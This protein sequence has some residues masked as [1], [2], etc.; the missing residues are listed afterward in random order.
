M[1]PHSAASTAS[2]AGTPLFVGRATLLRTLQVNLPQGR[3]Y[4][5]LAGPKTGRTALLQQLIWLEKQR[6]RTGGASMASWVP[7]YLDLR[8]ARPERPQFLFDA[9]WKAISKAVLDPWV[10][11]T[12]HFPRADLVDFKLEKDPAER[13][14]RA[15]EDL[16][17]QLANTQGW[18][19]WALLCDNA[20]VLAERGVPR[21]VGEQ[22][23]NLCS[24]QAPHCPT[25]MLWVGA[26]P[27][28]DM[29]TTGPLSALRRLPMGVL[30]DAE[31]QALYRAA[32]RPSMPYDAPWEVCVEATG[33][34]PM[35][36]MALMQAVIAQ[37]DAAF[38]QIREACAPEVEGV[39]AAYLACMGPTHDS[40]GHLHVVHALMQHLLSGGQD[41][42]VAEAEQLL[43]MR[44]VKEAIDMLESFA[45]IERTIRGNAPMLR[46]GN[47]W[48]NSW[49]AQ[50]ANAPMA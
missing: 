31:A 9:L 18:C 13:F 47:P 12:D 35:L 30:R 33:R 8:M 37:P 20:E 16:W 14:A 7:V 6:A 27:L 48:W 1:P 10:Q 44:P 49:Y 29:L 4:A 40:R 15:C 50:Q 21:H 5:L 45:V 22:L 25:S 23:M 3:S 17:A 41:L 19:R 36:L 32:G 24:L 39:F 46:A 26:P 28:G 2:I 38:A 42:S 11:G 43:G 34:H